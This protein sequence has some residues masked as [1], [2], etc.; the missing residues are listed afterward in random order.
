MGN[1][2][3]A[4]LRPADRNNP[5]RIAALA[6][7]GDGKM[8]EG[9]KELDGI[10]RSSDASPVDK[11]FVPIYR[12]ITLVD[13][14]QYRA[15]LTQIAKVMQLVDGGQSAATPDKERSESSSCSF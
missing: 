14:S 13:A 9:M 10:E 12:A 4:A 2:R 1:A 15:G 7:L 11:A 8:A 6:A 3:S 5:D